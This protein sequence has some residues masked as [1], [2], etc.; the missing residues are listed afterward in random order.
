MPLSMKKEVIGKL[1]QE[2]EQLRKKIED[3]AVKWAKEWAAGEIH[4]TA[5]AR[6]I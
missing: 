5:T 6:K 4:R 2:R 1:A 3:A